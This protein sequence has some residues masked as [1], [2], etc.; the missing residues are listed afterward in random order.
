M[1]IDDLTPE[2]LEKARACKTPEEAL[3]L[4]KSIGRRLSEKDLEMI[5]GG[6]MWG[7]GDHCI[8]CGSNNVTQQTKKTPDGDEYTEYTCK[9]CGISWN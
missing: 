7:Q 2:Q 9:D 5:S 8:L 3:S 1:S 4:A 6:T